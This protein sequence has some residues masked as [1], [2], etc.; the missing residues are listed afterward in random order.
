VGRPV[1]GLDL[2]SNTFSCAIVGVGADGV[3]AV[4]RDTSVPVRL[5]EGLLPGGP[6]LP[7]AV[8]RGL[9]TL[10]RLVADFGL[11]GLPARA[12]A[13]AAL[14]MA[15]DPATFTGP[16]S[17]ILGA[18]IEIIDGIAEALLTV[19]G[20]LLGLPDRGPWIVLDI[21]GQST[22]LCW[23]APGGEWTPVSVPLGVVGL[24]AAHLAHDPARPEEL[25]ELGDDV[26][27]ALERSVPRDL[28]GALV[29]VA[30]T[31]TTLAWL[32]SG[33]GRW[34]RRLIHGKGLSRERAS[35]WL[36]RMLEH[37]AAGRTE[38]FG[39]GAGRADVFP[40]GLVILDRVLGHLGRED[41]VVS[42]NGLRVGAALSILP[43]ASDA[44][45]SRE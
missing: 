17:A 23:S 2:G 42:A 19:R 1:A 7:A 34:D 36:G 39:V 37:D 6:L 32:E 15:A 24:T 14:R 16:A 45:G 27:A 4:L 10:E 35:I 29:A 26:S 40:A 33:Q 44:A 28:P 3:P 22:E 43:E 31:A 20:A 41:F 13:T 9:R 8:G 5:S 30:G 18:P 21:G 11:R 12:V 25:A 38:R